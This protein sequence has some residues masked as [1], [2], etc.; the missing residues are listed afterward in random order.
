M[1]ITIHNKQKDLKLASATLKKMIPFL[2]SELGV[3]TNEVIV[4][5][6][7]DAKTKKIHADFFNDPS[8]TDC[9]SFPIDLPSSKETTSHILGE[10]FVCPKTAITYAEKKG[11]DPYEETTLYVIHGLLHL[12]GYD[13]LDPISKRVMRKMEKRCL[14]I[15]SGFSLKP[16]NKT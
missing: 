5:F 6:I 1:L 8:S 16:K 14:K 4:H 2:L 3:Y 12:I 7:S 9:M 10:I 15:T 13:D 11:I